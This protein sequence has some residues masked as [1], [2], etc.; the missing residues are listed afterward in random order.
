MTRRNLF[1][2][3]TFIKD[4]VID[5]TYWKAPELSGRCLGFK[6]LIT[7]LTAEAHLGADINCDWVVLFTLCLP[8]L[9][10]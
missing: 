2:N 5:G 10:Y 6:K 8:A 7:L 4:V 3:S 9:N 1:I